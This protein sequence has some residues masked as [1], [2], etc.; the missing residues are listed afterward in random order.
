MKAILLTLSA[1]STF[2]LMT[3]AHADK[4]TI[5]LSVKGKIDVP[6]C[7]I[8]SPGEGVYD[9]GHLPST[10]IKPGNEKTT[11]SSMTKTWVVKC[12]ATTFLNFTVTDNRSD[13]T[14]EA[15]PSNFGLGKV[16]SDGKL[17]YYT[18]LMEN[19]TVDGKNST[20]FSAWPNGGGMMGSSDVYLQN[21]SG[22]NR[23][24][25]STGQGSS[26]KQAT[27][28]TF[29]ADLVVTPTLAGSGSMN[30]ALT[31]TVDLDGS[32]TLT[33]AFGI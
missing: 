10:L 17:G 3:S 11:L 16:N 30:G 21:P 8:G 6:S 27:G 12:D 20:V 32:I 5:D 24:G 33:F 18:V 19:G 26:A 28:Q 15:N 13:S 2:S 25:W 22:Q 9:F 23:H 7:I 1:A 29:T 31:D 14:S 4:P